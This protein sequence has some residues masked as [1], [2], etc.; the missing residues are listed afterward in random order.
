MT[1][2]E[3]QSGDIEAMTRLT[4]QLGYPAAEEQVARRMKTL[5]GKAD[6]VVLVAVS[7][8]GQAVGWLHVR[9]LTSLHVDSMGEICG[10]VVDEGHRSQGIGA[11]LV[12]AAER[13]TEAHGCRKMRVRSNAV[14]KD[15]HR[16]YERAGFR[17]TKT[18]L[19][20]EKTW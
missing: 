13:W 11:A 17:M 12:L 9:A 3:L 18:S 20:F 7:D 15:A 1:I 10:M 2:R 5:L 16:F 4:S 8:K 6:E 19:T 14:R